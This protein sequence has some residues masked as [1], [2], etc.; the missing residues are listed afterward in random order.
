MTALTELD[1]LKAL[2]QKIDET[3]ERLVETLAERMSY[4]PLVAAYKKAHGLPVRQLDRERYVI[5]QARAKA[6]RQGCPPDLVEAVYRLVI[7]Y[8][9]KMEE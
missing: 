8:A 1:D 6:A 4:I 5:E 3:D 9:S 2:R 7:D